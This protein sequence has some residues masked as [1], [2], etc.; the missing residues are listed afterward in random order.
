VIN[1]Y[2]GKENRPYAKIWFESLEDKTIA[3]V[4]VSRSPNP[5][6][7]R[8]EGK[9]EFYIRLGNSSHPLN[10]REAT[11]YIKDHWK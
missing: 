7:I 1:K 8:F 5:V 4:K 9:E 11:T 6:Y 10:V 2:L 3:V